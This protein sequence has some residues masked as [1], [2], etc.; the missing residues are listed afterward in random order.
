MSLQIFLFAFGLNLIL[1]FITQENANTNIILSIKHG[2]CRIVPGKEE[3]DNGSNNNSSAAASPQLRTDSP[4][5]PAAQAQPPNNNTGSSL[6]HVR[7]RGMGG[8]NDPGPPRRI[9]RFVYTTL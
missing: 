9:P 3:K 1:P 7:K 4:V 8:P 2:T 6:G 5:T